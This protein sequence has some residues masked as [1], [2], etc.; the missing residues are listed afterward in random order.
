[1][2]PLS[3]ALAR[4]FRALRLDTDVAR[5]D[6]VRA[7][8]GAASRVIGPNAIRTTALSVD[9]DNLDVAVSS[10]YCAVEICLLER[11]AVDACVMA[12]PRSGTAKIRSVPVCPSPPLTFS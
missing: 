7:W 11:V 3:A 10:A 6:A 8:H 4:A 2:R 9:D 1:M 5:A 12:A